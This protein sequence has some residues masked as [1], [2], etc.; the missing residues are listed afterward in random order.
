MC[1]QAIKCCQMLRLPVSPAIRFSASDKARDRADRQTL[2]E[3]T[4]YG[5]GFE[6]TGVMSEILCLIMSWLQLS[7]GHYAMHTHTNVPCPIFATA[8]GFSQIR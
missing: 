4:A 2:R 7:P 6:P 3:M 5:I 1:W 8:G